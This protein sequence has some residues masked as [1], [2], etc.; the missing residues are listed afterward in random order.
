MQQIADWLEKL[1][2]SEYAQRFA[3]NGI[4]AEALRHLTDQD[5]KDIGVLLG[6]RRVMLAAIGEL[7]GPAAAALARAPAAEPKAQETA[8]RLQEAPSPPTAAATSI[9]AAI[10]AAG[11]RRHVTVMFCD[12][13]D[14]TGIAAKLDAEEWRD[15]VGAYLDATSAAVTEMGGKVAKK[16]GDGLMALFGYPVA[17]ENDAERAARAA[18]AIQRALAELN[19]KN[20]DTAMPALA[21][22]IAIESGPV[23]VDATGEIFGDVPNIAARA[24][25]LAEPGSVVVT[26]RV[27]RQI[28]GLFVVEERGSHELK[29]VPELVT[30]YRIVRASGG[31]RRTGQRHLTPLIGRDEEMAML[32]RR[33]ERARR[34]A[35]GVDPRRA[36]IGQI[37]PDRGI[38][39]AAERR[40]AYMDG[41]ELLTAVAKHAAA[42]GRRMG[43]PA[44]WRCRRR[45]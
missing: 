24:Q 14:S 4:T 36:G 21:A 32:T 26:A 34:R 33:W 30:L 13:V 18:L 9:S 44:F 6:H 39:R 45:S 20:A 41:M 37:A 28:A 19:R 12:L 38:S 17:Q 29:G 16:L 15:L 22:R 11:E 31:G 10:G 8:E 5:L 2:M 25:A 42:P 43:P 27:Q 40:T 3:E 7:G 23:V 35:T 1:G